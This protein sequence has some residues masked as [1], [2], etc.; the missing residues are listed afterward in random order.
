MNYIYDNKGKRIGQTQSISSTNKVMYNN[1]GRRVG[2]YN[3][4]TDSTYDHTGKRVG[5]GDQTARF[6]Q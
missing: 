4:T 5:N 2:Y 3:K 6:L 1:T